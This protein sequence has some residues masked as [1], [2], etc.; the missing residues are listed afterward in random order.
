MEPETA[1]IS[2][3]NHSRSCGCGPEIIFHQHVCRP[4]FATA[5][6]E[7]GEEPVFWLWIGRGRCAD[8][9]AFLMQF[10]NRLSSS[11]PELST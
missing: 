10:K 7:A 3:G 2:L 4:R 6:S 5:Q 8:K 11:L 1:W 9:S